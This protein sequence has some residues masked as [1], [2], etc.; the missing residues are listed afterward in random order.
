MPRWT[1]IVVHHSEGS[2][3]TRL[4]TRTIR[5]YHVEHNRWD[6][7]GYHFLVERVGTGYEFI[8]G[9]PLDMSGAHARGSNMTHIGVCLVG[10]FNRSKPTSAQ[11]MA[12]ARHIRGLM[13]ALRIPRSAIR[14]HREVN[15][16]DC[17]GTRFRKRVLLDLVW[18]GAKAPEPRLLARLLL[19][20]SC[21]G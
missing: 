8:A 12:A 20:N 16:T 13:K 6:D 15:D 1:G 2:D 17:P 3:T 14:F 11:L 7:V 19:R 9:R 21:P 4:D 10:N 5:D 18:V